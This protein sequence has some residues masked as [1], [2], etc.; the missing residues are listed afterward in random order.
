MSKVNS[1][2]INRPVPLG[3]PGNKEWEECISSHEEGSE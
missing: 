3:D 2:E 1:K